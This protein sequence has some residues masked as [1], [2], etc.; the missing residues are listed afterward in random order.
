MLHDLHEHVDEVARATLHAKIVEHLDAHR[1]ADCEH[2]YQTV[3]SWEVFTSVRETFKQKDVDD[4][5]W[6]KH[7]YVVP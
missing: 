3:I 7:V 1:E 6:G 4:S 2:H 5:E